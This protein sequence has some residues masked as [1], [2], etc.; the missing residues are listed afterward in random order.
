M[1][2]I[3]LSLAGV[4]AATAFA[5]EASAIAAFA[6][7]TGMA[8]SACHQQ[9][10]PVLNSFGRAFKAGGYT[11]MGAQGKV[12]GDHLS[13]PDTL[14]LSMLLKLRYQDQGG[15][16]AA[17]NNLGDGI[18]V[19]TSNGQWQF[20]DE[21]V[22]LGGGRVAENVGF[23][24]EITLAKNP[25]GSANAAI[26]R[27][28]FAFDVGSVKLSVIPFTG[29]ASGV[30]T[31]Y[32][33][34]ST[35]S[36]RAN[37]W[38]E[39]RRD[40]SAVQYS[41]ADGNGSAAAWAGAAT[42]FA[43]VAQNDF[44]YVNYTRWTPNYMIGA[45]PGA[46]GGNNGATDMNSNY[47]R[48]AITP[49]YNDWAF[50][51]G[52]GI[53]TGKSE[54]QGGGAVGVVGSGNYDARAHFFDAQA[55]GKVGGKDLG[56]YATY[57]KAPVVSGT[58]GAAAVAGVVTPTG[59]NLFNTRG[60]EKWSWTIGADYSIIPNTLHIGAAYRDART[61]TAVTG[62]NQTDKSTMVQ[63]VYDF[64]QNI[65]LHATYSSRSGSRYAPTT[66]GQNETLFMLEAAW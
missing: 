29:D 6:R 18:G 54:L 19:D 43:F 58:C 59:C 4:L 63:A 66:A 49:S 40:I 13:I 20:G 22:I 7:Q 30:Q 60:L 11:M 9:H 38:S 50:H 55:H 10:F 32:E 53:M 65:A 21:L 31:G 3:V 27:M 14:N 25:N 24:T 52:L 1:K 34:G 57:A 48:I 64:T 33:L 41:L 62:G 2:K 17:A 28:P 37:R 8:C 26:F 56:L 36:L 23:F 44:G 39:Q 5:P 61:G 35:G 51:G 46:A 45:N 42:G 16:P 15:T 47:F 12:E